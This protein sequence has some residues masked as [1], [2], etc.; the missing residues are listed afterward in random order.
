MI[1]DVPLD[2]IEPVPVV[3]EQLI[4]ARRQRGEPP[5]VRGQHLFDI[6]VAD[7]AQ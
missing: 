7:S 3:L 6:E 1:E 2:D 5:L 4:D